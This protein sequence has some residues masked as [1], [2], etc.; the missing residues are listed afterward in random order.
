MNPFESIAYPTNYPEPSSPILSPLS[1]D[2][3]SFLLLAESGKKYVLRRRMPPNKTQAITAEYEAIGFTTK[4][5]GIFRQ[6]SIDEQETFIKN[7]LENNLPVAP[8]VI[9][10]HDGLI[11]PF[12]DGC[13]FSEFLSTETQ[14]ERLG[15]ITNAYFTD[16]LDAHSKSIIYGDRWGPNTIVT[17]DDRL[18]HIDLDVEIGGPNSKEFELAQAVYYTVFFA[19]TL[20]R[21]KI[22]IDLLADFFR[23]QQL[24]HKYDV[25]VVFDLLKSH[26]DFF[27]NK[28]YI[29]PEI[30][31][32]IQIAKENVNLP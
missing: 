22:I 30:D 7:C 27:Q 25:A 13:P 5:F 10:V 3:D 21:R 1:Y 6:R 29:C 15:R 24:S 32:L 18:W 20:N 4:Y 14:S 26:K 19:N 17:P 12:I 16:L 9:S 23:N 8:I 2:S 28:K 11:F 31:M